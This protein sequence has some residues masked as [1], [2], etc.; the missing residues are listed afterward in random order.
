MTNLIEPGLSEEAR[1][2]VSV[3]HRFAQEEMRPTGIELDKLADPEDVIAPGS[4]LWKLHDRFT[5]LGVH[6]L[7]EGSGFSPEEMALVKSHVSEEMGWGDAG[8][9][10]SL[11]VSPF[12]HQMINMLGSEE[13]KETYLSQEPLIGCWA[14]TEADHGSDSLAFNQPFYDDP[15]VKPNVIARRDGDHYV[16]SGSKSAWVSNG[17]IADIAS[18]HCAIDG[19]G[20]FNK[21]GICIVPLDLPGVS[22]GKNLDKLGQRSLPQGEIH[23]DEVRI[24]ASHMMMDQVGYSGVIELILALANAHMGSTFS[25]VAR[26]SYE[27]ALDYA[28]ERRQG[29]RLL[30]EHQHVQARLL[31]MFAKVQA[32]ISLS[33]LTR[34]IGAANGVAPPVQYSIASKVFC[35]T[36]AFEVASEAVQIFGGNGLTR[37]YPVE[38]LLR[39]ARA[40]MIEDGCNEMLS[41]VGGAQL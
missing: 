8:L 10:I 28:K 12:P 29:G 5:Q 35:T 37:E 32:S 22:K 3:I 21:G 18:M 27:L 41:I 38:K 4:S 2:I 34:L 24:P 25:G 16:L 31:K 11:A 1:E 19:D 36:A 20:G 9:S 6:E 40:A 7:E 13:L 14:I 30:I 15:A 39:D 33:R 26:A 23:L 17:V